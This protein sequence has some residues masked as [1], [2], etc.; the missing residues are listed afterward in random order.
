MHQFNSF[1]YGRQSVESHHAQG[2]GKDWDY[3]KPTT[4][5]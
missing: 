1:R 2:F 3:E 4:E 5:H